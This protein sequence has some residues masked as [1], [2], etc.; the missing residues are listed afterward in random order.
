[1]PKCQ[2]ASLAEYIHERIPRT[3][4]RYPCHA[5]VLD[6]LLNQM[7]KTSLDDI[8][9]EVRA[10]KDSN[11]FYEIIKLFPSQRVD[12]R[13]DVSQIAIGAF[14]RIRDLDVELNFEPN[15]WCVD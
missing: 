4:E 14:V 15:W 10:D 5:S 13:G 1:M 11:L 3:F 8:R 6:R 2:R 9:F 12:D 7:V